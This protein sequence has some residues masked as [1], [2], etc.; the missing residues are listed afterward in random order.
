MHK[1]LDIRKLI[2]WVGML[3]DKL[4][5]LSQTKKLLLFLSIPVS[6]VPMIFLL[7]LPY[8]EGEAFAFR[9]IIA[10]YLWVCGSLAFLLGLTFV[11]RWSIELRRKIAGYGVVGMEVTVFVILALIELCGRSPH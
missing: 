8:W 6:V 4:I 10:L 11:D 1:G 7:R 5:L 2:K 3:L 9:L